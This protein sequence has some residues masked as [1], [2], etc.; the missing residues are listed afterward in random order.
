M[1]KKE[2]P[3]KATIKVL[4]KIYKAEGDSVLEALTNLKPN[5]VSSG[6]SILAVG[7]GKE[8]KDRVIPAFRT[9]RMFSASPMIREVELKKTSLMFGV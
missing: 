9:R 6:M 5:G 7:K 3:Y 4:G 8:M 1:T 2:K